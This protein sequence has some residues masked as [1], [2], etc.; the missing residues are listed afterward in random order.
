[1][2]NYPYIIP[3]TPSY[4]EHCKYVVKQGSNIYGQGLVCSDLLY[5]STEYY[6]KLSY[7]F[8][9]AA[10]LRNQHFVFSVSTNEECYSTCLHF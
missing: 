7:C 10:Y 5:Y 3:F 9:T 1:M 6:C 2:E 4:L 8:F